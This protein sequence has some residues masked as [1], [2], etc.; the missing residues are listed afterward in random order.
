MDSIV[1]CRRTISDRFPIASFRVR[2]PE[3]RYYEVACATDPRLFHP[4]YAG[5]RSETNFYTSRSRGLIGVGSGEHTWFVPPEVLCRF[6]GSRRIYYALGTYGGPNGD[7]PRFS[8]SPAALDRVPSLALAQD[9]TGRTLDRGRIGRAGRAKATYG[10]PEG[11]SSLRWG[12]DDAMEYE[13]QL[14]AS[15]GGDDDDDDY[16]DGY[17]PGLWHAAGL[18]ADDDDDDYDDELEE[19]EIED[20]TQLSSPASARLGGARAALDSMFAVDPE[21]YGGPP[22]RG[23]PRRASAARSGQIGALGGV[24]SVGRGVP[25]FGG[26]PDDDELEDGTAYLNAHPEAL[27]GYGRPPRRATPPA[28]ARPR[29]RSRSRPYVGGAPAHERMAYG[30]KGTGRH[31]AYREEHREESLPVGPAARP[32]G[33]RALEIPDMVDIVRSVGRAES[34][35]DGYQA[36]VRDAEFSDP[37]HPAFGRYHMGLSWGIV[38]FNQRS[39]ALGRVLA[40][41]KQRDQRLGDSLP[42]EHRF[43][44]LFGPDAAALL[45]TTD[46]ARTPQPQERVAPVGGAVL[47][48]QPWVKRFED[49]GAVGYV[50]AA[51]NE[52]AVEDYVR[53]MLPIARALELTTARGLALLVDRA[54]HMGVGAGA[55]W[56]MR[57]AGPV[58][59]EAER[60]EA[61]RALGYEPGELAR[62]QREHGVSPADGGWGPLTHAALTTAMRRL[63]PSSPLVLPEAEEAM[64]SLLDA[65]ED[66]GFRDRMLALMRSDDFDDR[67]MFE[68]G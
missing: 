43:A 35:D 19:G 46:P 33:Q 60:S 55:S 68:L 9:F 11:G 63:G 1:P 47:W 16:D 6:A 51:Q 26:S 32:L 17:D 36:T 44:R 48:E 42:A 30:R 53:P 66:T 3:A 24:S 59:S 13:R 20:G 57:A 40:L 62:F 14:S 64:R 23:I 56:V 7:N 25:R 41:A 12:G 34:G 18:E 2:V 8:I 21:G 49:A 15:L 28:H 10:R 67:T 52:V 61:L 31:P 39:G 38:L 50:Q 45:A 65:A 27:G 4:D 37:T 58:R 22:A 5:S 54:V 29:S